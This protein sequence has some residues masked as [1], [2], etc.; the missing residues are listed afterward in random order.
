MR[1]WI[2]LDARDDAERDANEDRVLG[3]YLTESEMNID[4]PALIANHD[5]EWASECVEVNTRPRPP[6]FR[7]DFEDTY[8]GEGGDLGVKCDSADDARQA[9][10]RSWTDVLRDMDGSLYKQRILHWNADRTVATAKYDVT[11]GISETVTYT[12]RQVA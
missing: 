12:V 11:R 6:E 4:L 9:A 1:V 3:V 10:Q 8:T 5:G 2:V 7:V